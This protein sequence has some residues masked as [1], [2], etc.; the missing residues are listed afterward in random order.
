MRINQLKVRGFR[1]FNEEQIID[2]SD[3]IAVFEG[4][5]GSGKTSLAEA[6]EWLLYGKTLKRIKGEELSKREYARCYRNTH[7]IRPGLP[8]VEANITD[9]P[10]SNHTIVRELKGDESLVPRVDGMPKSDLREFGIDTMYDRL[11]I[12]QHTLQ[13]FI[14]MKTKGRYEMLS[15]M[16]GLEPLMTFRT[17]VES[18]KT[19]FNKRIL[20]KFEPRRRNLWVTASVSEP[21]H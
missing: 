17:T 8:F 6:I 21:C 15:A 20:P 10:G 13:D 7:F 3:P 18:G 9:I 2:L 16:L 4:P 12:L 5:D 19:E 14:F 11:L 1:A